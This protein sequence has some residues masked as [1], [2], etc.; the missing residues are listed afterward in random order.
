MDGG[1]Y[2]LKYKQIAY[3]K[4]S[5]SPK[6]IQEIIGIII[7]YHNSSIDTIHKQRDIAIGILINILGGNQTNILCIQF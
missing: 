6:L 5:L 7:I 2:S 3:S 1:N 4:L